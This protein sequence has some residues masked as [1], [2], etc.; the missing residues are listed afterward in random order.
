[1]GLLHERCVA[2]GFYQFFV[3][4]C[5]LLDFMTCGNNTICFCNS[6]DNL[7]LLGLIINNFLLS[8]FSLE[9]GSKHGVSGCDSNEN[10]I[11]FWANDGNDD[12][13]FHHCGICN[14][15]VTLRNKFSIRCDLVVFSKHGF[16][17][18]SNV[19]KEK[20]AI[21]FGMV[22]ELWPNVSSFDSRQGILIFVS[23]WNEKCLNTTVLAIYDGLSID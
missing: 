7:I 20:V 19:C 8:T 15:W 14:S 12:S 1:M 4:L 21:F 2:F 3:F 18:N 17:G 13:N 9:L 6:R 10:S 16:S 23:D 5:N 22:S 11:E